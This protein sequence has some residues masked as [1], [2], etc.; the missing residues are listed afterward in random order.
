MDNILDFTKKPT[1]IRKPDHIMSIY[2]NRNTDRPSIDCMTFVLYGDG[3]RRHRYYGSKDCL[4]T[5]TTG[6]A[7]S[8]FSSVCEDGPHLGEPVQ[9]YDLSLELQKHVRKRVARY[10]YYY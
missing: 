8:R 9:W 7:F 5:C 1:L 10:C 3:W 6:R 4:F 2:D